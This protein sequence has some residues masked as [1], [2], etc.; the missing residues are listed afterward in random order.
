MFEF[1]FEDGYRIGGYTFKTSTS[2]L[3]EFDFTFET[4]ALRTPFF[5]MHVT[6]LFYP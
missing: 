3:S 6:I 4:L 5:S 2:F 1:L